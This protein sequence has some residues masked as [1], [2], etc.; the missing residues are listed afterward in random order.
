MKQQRFGV[1][2]TRLQSES[3]TYNY[4]KVSCKYYTYEYIYQKIFHHR[5]RYGALAFNGATCSAAVLRLFVVNSFAVCS[6]P[7]LQLRTNARASASNAPS[8]HSTLDVSHC[9]D[10]NQVLYAILAPIR[11]YTSMINQGKREQSIST[12]LSGDYPHQALPVKY[13]H[14]LEFPAFF[15]IQIETNVTE[16]NRSV[17]ALVVNS[18]HQV[19][20]EM[21]PI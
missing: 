5:A 2:P 6:F 8:N 9:R 14:M 18:C 17:T 3:L 19:G 16:H 15:G 12:N 1:I 7:H 20:C 13:M 21:N 10:C 4:R 11:T